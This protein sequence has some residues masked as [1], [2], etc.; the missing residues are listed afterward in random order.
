[1]KKSKTESRTNMNDVAPKKGELRKVSVR[2]S[3]PIVYYP[4]RHEELMERL[5]RAGYT[6]IQNRFSENREGYPSGDRF[7]AAH[8]Q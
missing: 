3:H 2:W 7:V 4:F 1:M 8:G 6:N 5:R